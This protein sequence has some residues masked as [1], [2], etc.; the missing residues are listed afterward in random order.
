MFP[1]DFTFP[2]DFMFLS[3]D[4]GRGEERGNRRASPPLPTSPPSGERR[5]IGEV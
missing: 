3:P 2:F 1:P 4:R 5:K